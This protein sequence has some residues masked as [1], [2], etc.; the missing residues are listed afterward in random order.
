[1]K[2]IEKIQRFMYG[3]YGVDELYKF[4]FLVYFGL[5]IV[6]L[7]I[8]NFV[9]FIIQTL[10]LFIM[11]YR[12]FSKNINRRRKENKMYLKIK[13]K[14]LSPFDNIKKN[15]KDKEHVYVKCRKCKKVLRIPIPMERGI[16]KVKCPNCGKRRKKLVLKKVKVEIITNKK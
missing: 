6:D 2:Y 8:H 15:I 4:L 10:I 1:M 14:L 13:N 7:F 9:L 5:I 3:R 16:K 11:F 12:V